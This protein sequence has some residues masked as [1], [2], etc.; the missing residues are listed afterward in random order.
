MALAPSAL[1]LSDANLNSSDDLLLHEHVYQKIFRNLIVD[2][3]QPSEAVT[4]RGLAR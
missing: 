3:F 1:G 4:L 2:Q